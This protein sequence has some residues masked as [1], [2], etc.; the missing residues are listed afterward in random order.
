MDTCVQWSMDQ[1][2]Q[3]GFVYGYIV[4][5]KRAIRVASEKEP[6]NELS[7]GSLVFYP[8]R[9]DHQGIVIGINFPPED[10]SFKI[11][12]VWFED[13]LFPSKVR[14]EDVRW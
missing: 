8:N 4:D 5:Q 9:G 12:D 10:G 1:V 11:L 13:D 14:F 3:G 7:L 2:I 6:Q